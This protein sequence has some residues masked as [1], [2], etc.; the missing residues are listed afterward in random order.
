MAKRPGC[1]LL[2]P[3]R[4]GNSAERFTGGHVYSVTW[5]LPWEGG[6]GRSEASRGQ[7][8]ARPWSVTEEQLPGHSGLCPRRGGGGKRACEGRRARPG[9]QTAGCMSGC[10]RARRG[11]QAGGLQ[12]PCG[13]VSS[14]LKNL[15]WVC[16]QQKRKREGP[17][18]SPPP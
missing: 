4:P 6:A 5:Q 18:E 1:S 16:H 17:R 8:A 9:V 7:Q 10:H 15:F 12:S 14:E 13:Q 2:E 11:G 3:W